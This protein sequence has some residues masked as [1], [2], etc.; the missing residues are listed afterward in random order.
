VIQK[1]AK[2]NR[3]IVGPREALLTREV[4]V[5]AA[6]LHA[7]AG[8]VDRVKLRYRSAAIGARVREDAAAG[9]HRTLTL[10]LNEPMMGAAPGQLACLMDG[11]L[12]VGWATIAG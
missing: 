11:E 5:R 3:V 9:R 1:D 4:R 7:A 6:R 10:E 8:R 2:L 12:V